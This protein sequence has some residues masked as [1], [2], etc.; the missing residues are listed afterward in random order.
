LIVTKGGI[1]FVGGGDEAFHAVDKKTG[2]DL[3]SWPT[4]GI[5]TTG[6]P[7]T[8]SIGGKQYVVIAIGG[9]G[10]EASLIAFSL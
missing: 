2:A 7:M 10:K 4:D 5:K 8:Y 3:W 9:A 1:V 6:T